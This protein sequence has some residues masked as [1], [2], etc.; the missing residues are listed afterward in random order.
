LTVAGHSKSHAQKLTD[1]NG[2]GK[3]FEIAIVIGVGR[4]VARF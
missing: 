2:L 4:P 3:Q 1:S